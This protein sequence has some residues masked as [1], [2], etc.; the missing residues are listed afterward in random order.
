MAFERNPHEPDKFLA[1]DASRRESEIRR[2]YCAMRM[3][4]A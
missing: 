2:G 4:R 1:G 3:S